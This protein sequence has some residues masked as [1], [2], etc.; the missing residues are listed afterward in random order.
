MNE[1]MLAKVA[2]F[3]VDI[4]GADRGNILRTLRRNAPQYAHRVTHKEQLTGYCLGRS[5]SDFE[6]IGP[7]VAE[8]LVTA[9]SLLQVALLSCAGYNIIVD[10]PLQHKTWRQYLINNSFVER[11]PFTRMVL[12]EPVTVG[13][14]DKQFAIA[15]PEIG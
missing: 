14:P 9:Q 1:D 2:S 11:R 6:Q 8:D 3:D 7:V 15:G 13:Q 4:F 5:G 12:G 10:V